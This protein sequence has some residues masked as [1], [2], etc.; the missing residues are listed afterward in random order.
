MRKKKIKKGEATVAEAVSYLR[1]SK[2][3][4]LKDFIAYLSE[5]PEIISR[6]QY[7]KNFNFRPQDRLNSINLEEE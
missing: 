3:F 1:I 5:D 4:Y 7:P 6:E 2:D